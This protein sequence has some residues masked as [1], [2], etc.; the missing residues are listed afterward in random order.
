MEEGQWM[1]IGGEDE[2]SQIISVNQNIIMEPIIS[3]LTKENNGQKIT[4]NK[5]KICEQS[6]INS[7]FQSKIFIQR[8]SAEVVVGTVDYSPEI[9]FI[10]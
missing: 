6:I 1:V 4:Q 8:M 9:S 2:Q 5:K 7:F 3:M 10:T